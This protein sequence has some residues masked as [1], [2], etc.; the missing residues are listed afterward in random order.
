MR[1]FFTATM[2]AAL[3]VGAMAVPVTAAGPSCSHIIGSNADETKISLAAFRNDDDQV[4]GQFYLENEA[5]SCKQVTYTL[6]VLEAEGDSEPIAS[7]SVTGD[8]AADF[9]IIEVNDVI[10]ADNTVCVYVTAT[11]GKKKITDRGPDEGCITLTD[12]GS[13]GGGGKG[14]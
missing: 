14:F 11:I 5:S 4:I 7:A 8:G 9:V 10:S 13:S 12:D 6:Y 3:L 2:T 1:R